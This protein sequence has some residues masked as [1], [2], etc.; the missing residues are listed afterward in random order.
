MPSVELLALVL[1]LAMLVIAWTYYFLHRRS[2]T[3]LRALLARKPHAT[4]RAHHVRLQIHSFETMWIAA[5]G[6]TAMLLA[7]LLAVHAEEVEL[8]PDMVGVVLFLATGTCSV[9][10]NL[11]HDIRLMRRLGLEC[12]SCRGALTHWFG[13][14]VLR[15]GQ[16][17][18]CRMI[19][20]RA[21]YR[22]AMEQW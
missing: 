22:R 6:L 21:H 1:G 7:G 8:W 17:P 10:W 2:L 18:R 19:L 3:R 4:R 12:P 9:V 20:F 13:R 15:T 16:C 11:V 14:L 5:A